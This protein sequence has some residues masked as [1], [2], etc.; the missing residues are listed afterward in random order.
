MSISVSRFF[1]ISVGILLIGY[2]MFNK[3]FAYVGVPPL[4]IGEVFLG[5]SFFLL[6]AG[7]Y[8]SRIFSSPLMW[9]IILFITWGAIRTLPYIETYGLN[10]LRDAVVWGY[11][12]YAV[13]VAGALL[14]GRLVGQVPRW[15]SMWF[16]WFLVI[17]PI[18]YMMGQLIP[19]RLPKWPG[20]ET[21]FIHMKPG[22]MAVHLAGVAGFLGLGLHRRFLKAGQRIS[23]AK[24][25]SLW[26]IWGI[27]VIAAGSRNRGG[28]LSVFLACC[29][30]LMFKPMG[31]LNRVILPALIVVFLGLA[32]DIKVPVGGDRYFSVQQIL[33]NI[34]SVVSKS[35]KTEL[36]GTA[37]WRLE[38]WTKIYKETVH[39]EFFWDGR[40]YGVDL[41]QVHNF[42]DSTKNRSPHNGHLTIL[43]RS[44]MP[45]LVLWVIFLGLVGILL[46]QGYFR[47]RSLGQYDL[48]DLN[49]WCMA[50]LAAFMVNSSFDVY[51]EGPQGGIWF[52]ALMGFVV[53]LTEEQR[54]LYAQSVASLRPEPGASPGRL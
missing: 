46:L 28:M 43:A 2:A 23:Q 5:F 34:E 35:D 7:S 54:L 33:D 12:F 40:G 14:Q 27:G 47:M 6:L 18:I 17:A 39:G 37:S 19:E 52:W 42:A 49:V 4:F 36:T 21:S 15:F 9:L 51:L 50:Y 16:P 53:A 38:W 8:S 31:R 1:L 13:F 44:G 11:A 3:G 48:A 26:M 30:I 10:A 41:S 24:E 45:G 25:F 29:I 32:F 20:T 22:D